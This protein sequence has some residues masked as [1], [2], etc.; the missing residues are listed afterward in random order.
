[1]DAGDLDTEVTILS[2]SE[3]T[4]ETYGS[5]VS[6]WE[7]GETVWAQVKDVLP[8]RAGL[9]AD[10]IDISRRPCRIRMRWRDDISLKNRFRIGTRDLQIIA[11]PAE[12]GRRKWVEFMAEE[13]STEGDR[14]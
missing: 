8:S 4:D 10:Q 14:S 13:L 6:S 3:G 11:G 12:I 2:R 1:M 7:A 9:A 5:P